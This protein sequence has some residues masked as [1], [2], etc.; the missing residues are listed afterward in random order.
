MLK[1]W[2]YWELMFQSINTHVSHLLCRWISI[3][4][5]TVIG[6][7]NMFLVVASGLTEKLSSCLAHL[8][9]CFHICCN[10]AY[11]FHS[12]IRAT[13][14]SRLSQS[15]CC[16]WPGP[17]WSALIASFMGPKWGPPGPTG[18]RWA[19]CWPHELC[20][21]GRQK[22]VKSS[23]PSC[24][25]L[26]YGMWVHTMVCEYVIKIQKINVPTDYLQY[27]KR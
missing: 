26:D 14:N 6:C 7:C 22:P 24:V 27:K 1:T 15:S 20:Y 13:R 11:V 5:M 2:V 19:P 4:V 10:A 9:T 18:P 3:E 12:N 21:L 17:W 23:S 8:S 25:M 16:C